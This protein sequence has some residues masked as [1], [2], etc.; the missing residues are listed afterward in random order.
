MSRINNFIAYLESKTG[1][2]YVWG[3]QGENLT[4]MTVS[5]LDEYIKKHESKQINRN[6]VMAAFDRAK[7]GGK[8]PIEA[9]DCSGLIIHYV[10]DMM[11][12]VKGDTT[13]NGLYG[14]CKSRGKLAGAALNKGDLVFI[15]K[16][17]KKVH[18]GVYVGNGYTIEAY[19]RDLGV[20]KRKLSLGEWTHWGRL[21][22]LQGAAQDGKWTVNRL[23]KLISPAQKGEDVKELQRRLVNAGFKAVLVNGELKAVKT[24]GIY[25]QITAAA[26]KAY[27][28]SVGLK[29]DGMAGK[30][31]ITALGGIWRG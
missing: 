24:D 21:P 23:L 6:R 17:V 2:I 31:T 15:H 20:I 1:N 8:N 5:K 13:A 27:Q 14:M 30:K 29:A 4:N 3:A 9:Y 11:H 7:A 12:W 18:V 10:C 22:V 28:K 25:G 19:G 26:V 16:G